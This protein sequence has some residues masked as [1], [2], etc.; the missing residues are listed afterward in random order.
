MHRKKIW[1]ERLQ[2]AE[3]KRMLSS[4]KTSIF[5]EE[6]IHVLHRELKVN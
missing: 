5:C 4:C 2:H 3:S 6:C 1:K